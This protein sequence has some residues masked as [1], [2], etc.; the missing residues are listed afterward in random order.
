MV[1]SVGAVAKELH[2]KTAQDVKDIYHN[3]VKEVVAS[4]TEEDHPSVMERIHDAVEIVTK[5]VLEGIEDVGE[6]IK[7]H[8]EMIAE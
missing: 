1:D 6:A 7:D 4:T 3:T 5:E 8:P 2:T